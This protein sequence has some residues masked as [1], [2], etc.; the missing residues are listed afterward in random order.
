MGGGVLVAGLGVVGVLLILLFFKLGEREDEKHFVLQMFFLAFIVFVMVLIGKTAIDY[1]D[2]CDWHMSNSTVVGNITSY[3]Y[4]YE[5]NVNTNST[6][7]TFYDMTVW[8]MR[9]VVIYLFLYFAI[10]VFYFLRDR[11]RGGQS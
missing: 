10:E 6:S 4:V 7:S 5:C 1:K 2:D 3:D 8:I 9:I 11:A